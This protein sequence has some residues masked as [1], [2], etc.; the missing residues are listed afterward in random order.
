MFIF[1]VLKREFRN[2]KGNVSEKLASACVE[3]LV[4]QFVV[5][6]AVTL[7]GLAHCYHSFGETCGLHIYCCGNLKSPCKKNIRGAESIMT[8]LIERVMFINPVVGY[9]ILCS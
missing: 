3:V 8:L 6:S 9:H 7:C 1:L 2:T 5:F 4:L